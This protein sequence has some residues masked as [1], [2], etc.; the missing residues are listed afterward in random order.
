[1]HRL[2]HDIRPKWQAL[3][4]CVEPPPPCLL[5]QRCLAARGPE[6]APTRVADAPSARMRLARIHPVIHVDPPHIATPFCVL[7]SNSV[8]Q[9]HRVCGANTTFMAATACG[10][11]LLLNAPSALLGATRHPSLR[12]SILFRVPLDGE[13]LLLQPLP[14]M[15]VQH[16]QMN[17]GFALNGAHFFCGVVSYTVIH[18]LQFFDK[19]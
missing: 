11:R 12:P 4:L 19:N 18:S 8:T 7:G 2:G 1:M 14:D 13:V 3:Q 17:A 5:L 6:C 16:R 9:L 15:R 10:M